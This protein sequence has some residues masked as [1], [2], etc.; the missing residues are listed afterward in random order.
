MELKF[1][2]PSSH[3]CSISVQSVMLSLLLSLICLSCFMEEHTASGFVLPAQ[4][5]SKVKRQSAESSLQLKTEKPTT[6]DNVHERHISKKDL[7]NLL[8]LLQI[9]RE[10]QMTS[11]LPTMSSLR[12]R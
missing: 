11:A 3:L 10:L 2:F 4:S 9:L 6:K 8:K 7:S 12:F 5:T 1:F